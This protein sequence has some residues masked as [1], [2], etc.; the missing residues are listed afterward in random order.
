MCKSIKKKYKVIISGVGGDELTIGYNKYHFI[1]KFSYLYN[2][3]NFSNV[4]V[5]L[6][7][8][9][10]INSKKT[11]LLNYYF[12]GSKSWKLTALKNGNSLKFNKD[13]FESISFNSLRDNSGCFLTDILNFDLEQ[14]L[15]FSYLSAIDR[16]SMRESVEIRTPFLNKLLF[17]KVSELDISNLI[18]NQKILF[19]KILSRYIPQKL[20]NDKKRG[21]VQP[22]YTSKIKK[23]R[24]KKFSKLSNKL[25]KEDYNSKKIISRINLI[26][27]FYS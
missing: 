17:E 20:I 18:K 26:N 5:N 1:K 14:T 7:N 19:K 9:F 3:P 15:P 24:F 22:V 4:L 8:L 6:I 27:S 21:F 11:N 13:L 2:N 16:G 10:G 23:N 12:R 25:E